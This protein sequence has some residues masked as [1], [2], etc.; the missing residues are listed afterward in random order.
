MPLI[1]LL[2]LI[3]TLGK[4]F[5]K[6]TACGCESTNWWWARGFPYALEALGRGSSGARDELRWSRPRAG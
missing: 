5:F 6:G 1:K 4:E 3:A 2:L